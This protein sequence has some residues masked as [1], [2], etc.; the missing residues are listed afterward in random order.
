[1]QQ[2]KSLE[3]EKIIMLTGD[4]ERTAHTIALQLGIETYKAQLLPEDKLNYIK[5]LKTDYGK[6]AM[7]GDGVNDAPA[8]AL[9]DTGIAMGGTGTD[10]ALETGDVVLM[11][12][13]LLKLPVA[14]SLSRKAIANI[15]QNIIMSIAIVFLLILAAIFGF[16][17]LVSGLIINEVSA[18]IVIAN[19]FRLYKL[20]LNK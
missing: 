4:N 7:V 18:L 14:F 6:V 1:M 10:V 2:L 3:I 12:D 5:E 17:D 19:G 11:G 20:K 15:M 8:M 16:V 9:A 13:N